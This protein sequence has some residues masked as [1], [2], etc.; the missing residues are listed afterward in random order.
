METQKLVG[1]RVMN[2]NTHAIRT[3]EYIR[4]GIVTVNYHGDTSKYSYPSVF[5][6]L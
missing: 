3:I 4:D 2:T 6:R 5:A 1:M